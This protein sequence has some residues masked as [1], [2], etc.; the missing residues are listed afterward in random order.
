M[1]ERIGV[2]VICDT[3]HKEKPRMYT[4]SHGKNC[5]D[6]HHG[7]VDTHAVFGAFNVH[8]P[9]QAPTLWHT[10]KDWAWG[11]LSVEFFGQGVQPAIVVKSPLG[12]IVAIPMP[13]HDPINP[14]AAFWH[15]W[16]VIAQIIGVPLMKTQFDYETH[17]EIWP[18]AVPQNG[19]WESL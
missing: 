16:D 14:W 5:P 9:W 19:N 3:C 2:I 15:A 7:L 11:T 12:T 17:H 4:S 13:E 18:Y 6:C 8:L 1:A 10:Y